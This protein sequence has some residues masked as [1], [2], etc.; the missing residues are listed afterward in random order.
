MEKTLSALYQQYKNGILSKSDTEGKVFQYLLDNPDRYNQFDKNRDRWNEFLSWL[1]PRL[2]RALDSYTDLG[3]SFD[4]YI[5][6]IVHHTAKEYRS[7]EAERHITEY[8]CWQARAEEMKLYEN[9]P[10]YSEGIRFVSIPDDINPRQILILLL[11]S[12]YYAT[13]DMVKQVAKING[14]TYEDL[15]K[16]IDEIR[17]R[18][19][20]KEAEIQGLRERLH[21]QHYRYLAYQKRMNYALPG[22][23]YYERMKFRFEKAR[24]RY[25]AMRRRLGRMRTTASNRMIAELLGLP[26]GTVD[27]CLYAIKNRAVSNSLTEHTGQQL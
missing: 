5:S 21:C 25:Y 20:D 2:V 7:R 19:S 4:S 14:M 10:E 13:D 12:Y 1:Y 27:S 17:N 9:E 15:R 16:L 8:T 26:P 3:L 11:K 6:G 18:R 23:I 22:T 24:K